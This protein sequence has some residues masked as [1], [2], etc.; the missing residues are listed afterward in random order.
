MELYEFNQLSFED[1]LKI[2]WNDGIYITKVN[3]LALYLVFHFF[4]EVTL[5][6]EDI[7]EVNTF[8]RGEILDKYLDNMQTP[9][10]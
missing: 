10:F 7:V 9:D 5:N 8:V 2:I 1:K 6:E 4:A 3:N